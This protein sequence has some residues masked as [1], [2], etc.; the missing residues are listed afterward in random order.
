MF[1]TFG[2][3]LVDK[4]PHRRLPRR[5]LLLQRPQRQRQQR[6]QLVRHLL[7][8]PGRP[9]GRAQHRILVRRR[10]EWCGVQL[11]RSSLARGR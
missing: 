7:L 11:D 2:Y 1:I 3:S 10:D 9:R 4:G 8:R 6:Q 5:R